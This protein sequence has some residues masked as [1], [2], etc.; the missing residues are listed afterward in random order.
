MANGNQQM[1]PTQAGWYSA[2]PEPEAPKKFDYKKWGLIGVAVLGGLIVVLLAVFLIRSMLESSQTVQD[3]I[4]QQMTSEEEKCQDARDVAKCL[5]GV[6]E[7]LAQTNGNGAYCKELSG[8]QKDSCLSAAALTAK[9][10]QICDDVSDDSTKAACQDAVLASSITVASGFEACAG[11]HDEQVRIECEASW[12]LTT[13]RSG[14]CPAPLSATECRNGGYINAAVEA[15]DP[16]LCDVIDVLEFVDACRELVGPGDLDLDGV[17]ADE[18]ATRGTSDQDTDSDDDGLSDA[19]E[20]NIYKTDPAASDTDR[21]GFSDGT[22]V[23][24]GYNPLE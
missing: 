10:S 5:A 16:A 24:A 13:S 15:R 4:D 21:D 20:I 8:S 17:S 7:N 11:Y 9:D 12:K 1:D 22:E 23:S 6:P 14:E 18:E 2:T 3:T 19:D